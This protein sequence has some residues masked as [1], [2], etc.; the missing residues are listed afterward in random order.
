MID[1]AA[2]EGRVRQMIFELTAVDPDEIGLDDHLFLDLGMDSV[3]AMELVGMLDE[4]FDLEIE[5]EQA[6]QVRTVREIV[7]LATEHLEGA[8]AAAAR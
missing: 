8:H 1:S 4:S 3:S 7:D 6:M 5:I 2:L